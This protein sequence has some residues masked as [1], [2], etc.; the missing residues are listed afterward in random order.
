M[1]NLFLYVFFVDINFNLFFDG[2]MDGILPK[3][4][5]FHIIFYNRMIKYLISKMLV[6]I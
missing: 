3:M 4:Q 1:K 6:I 5:V 2:L